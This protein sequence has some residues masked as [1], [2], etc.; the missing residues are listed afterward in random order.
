MSQKTIKFAIR[1]LARTRN[2][3]TIIGKDGGMTVE[4]RQHNGSGAPMTDSLVA[5]ISG[6]KVELRVASAITLRPR[7]Y[8]TL[9]LWDNR[10]RLINIIIIS[11]V[12]N[13]GYKVVNDK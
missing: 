13:S 9:L 1:R 7:T 3:K 5:A 8:D 12:S 4:G 10:T 11:F 6:P 2:R